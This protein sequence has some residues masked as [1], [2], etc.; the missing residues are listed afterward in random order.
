[1]KLTN[2]LEQQRRIKSLYP[3]RI[4]KGPLGKVANNRRWKKST[5]KENT[6]KKM[7]HPRAKTKFIYFHKER[8]KERR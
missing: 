4:R 8:H 2:H 1:M 7:A 6:L 5:T 3:P